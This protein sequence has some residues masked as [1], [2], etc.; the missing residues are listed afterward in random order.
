M[1]PP[2]PPAP[3]PAP[4]PTREAAAEDLP[5]SSPAAPAKPPRNDRADDEAFE[6]GAFSVPPDEAV[7][8]PSPQF[9]TPDRARPDTEALA[10]EGTPQGDTV[11]ILKSEPGGKR[12]KVILIG[13]MIGIGAFALGVGGWKW[14]NRPSRYWPA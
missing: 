10:P 6:P 2:P 11:A 3:P 4:P 5:R 12:R 7:L 14:M 1:G 13:T 8:P 9:P